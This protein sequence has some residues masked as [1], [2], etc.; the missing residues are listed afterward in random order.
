MSENLTISKQ[1][2]AL[3]ARQ[4]THGGLTISVFGGSP[5]IVLPGPDPTGIGTILMAR[6]GKRL[7]EAE[8]RSKYDLKV[9]VDEKDGKFA[10]RIE[11][12]TGMAPVVSIPDPTDVVDFFVAETLEDAKAK[13]AASLDENFPGVSLNISGLNYRTKAFANCSLNPKRGTPPGMLTF[14]RKPDE[15]LATWVSAVVDDALAWGPTLRAA[16]A[17]HVM[18]K[19]TDRDGTVYVTISQEALNFTVEVEDHVVRP[20]TKKLVLKRSTTGSSIKPAIV[21]Y[22]TKT[23]GYRVHKWQVH[24]THSAKQPASANDP[25]F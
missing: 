6:S 25:W 9:Y 5:K 18:F 11:R 10:V 21:D 23:H 20:R 3:L 15:G 4:P 2:F 17:I 7:R 19:A 22:M 13:L 14:W 16:E 12:I 8:A 1:A 24:F